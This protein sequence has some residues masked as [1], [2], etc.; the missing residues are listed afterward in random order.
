MIKY[1]FSL[2]ICALIATGCS[3]SASNASFSPDPRFEI[4]SAEQWGSQ[5]DSL[6]GREHT[7]QFVTIHHAGTEWITG[8]DPVDKLTGLQSWGKREKDWPDLPYH[9]LIAPDGTIYEGRSVQYEPETNTNFDTTGHLNVHLWGNFE[10]QRV[11]KAQLESA[12][13]IS[14]YLMDRFD[15]SL[16][17]LGGHKDR[18][19]TAC[20]GKDLYRYI[21]DG[22]MS[23]WIED[24]LQGS[25]PAITIKDELPQGPEKF[26][27]T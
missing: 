17:T 10:V 19:E 25:S 12:A 20:P 15:I 13:Y 3:K 22:T 4:I 14:A 7:P 5:P 8:T 21:E 9:Y 1:L 2:L 26:I 24:H 18:A 11:N 23:E 16:E 27:G 6:E